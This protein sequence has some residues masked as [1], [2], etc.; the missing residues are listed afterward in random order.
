MHRGTNLEAAAPPGEAQPS[1]PWT[2]VLSGPPDDAA[3]LAAWDDLA[4]GLGAP[5]SA[6][7]C[8]L[9]WYRNVWRRPEQVRVVVARRADRVVGVWPLYFER[10]S[11]GFVTY[12]MAGHQT[13]VGV[14][15]LAAPDDVDARRALVAGLAELRPVPDRIELECVA[16]CFPWLEAAGSA[17]PAWRA[18]VD[19]DASRAPY[20]RLDD[21]TYTSWVER[22]RPRAGKNVA[23]YARRLAEHGYVRRRFAEHTEIVERL[24]VLRRLYL[25][26]KRAR[27]GWGADFDDAMLGMLTNLVAD[28]AHDERAVLYTVEKDPSSIAAI[29]LVL[30]AGDNANVWIGGVDNTF[31]QYSPGQVNLTEIIGDSHAHGL[32]VLSLGPGEEGY[33]ARYSTD[34]HAVVA[35]TLV[36]HSWNLRQLNTPATLL[37]RPARELARQVRARVRRA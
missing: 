14:E 30:I 31:P 15:P 7:S 12:R 35:T 11:W 4:V 34:A 22:R 37:P 2:E 27:G 23:R 18:Q 26:R 19:T 21:R 24:P 3:L 28:L 16:D 8:V 32:G 13:I 1:V 5:R 25:D 33:K 9:A 20:F 36:R 10:D 17:F 6:P 29:D